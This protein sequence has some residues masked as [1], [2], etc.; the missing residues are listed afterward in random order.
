MHSL[1]EDTTALPNNILSRIFESLYVDFLE[2]DEFRVGIGEHHCSLLH[3][4]VSVSKSSAFKPIYTF[5]LI[6]SKWN[7]VFL[8][9]AKLDRYTSH[10]IVHGPRHYH[11]H[12][13]T[14]LRR[15]V[16][17]GRYRVFHTLDTEHSTYPVVSL[18]F[19][20]H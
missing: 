20:F 14:L 10:Q 15:S 2:S 1:V 12:I 7:K 16:I 18:V 11:T 4:C 6:S 5:R 17:F 8:S 19:L 13:Y 3:P 9:T